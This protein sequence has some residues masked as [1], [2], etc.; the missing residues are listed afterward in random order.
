VRDVT[1]TAVFCTESTECFPLMT[2]KFFFKPF[3]TVT[4]A[5]VAPLI[6]VLIIHIM[7][8]IRCVSIHKLLHF[9]FL[10]AT[11]R[12]I[13]L[14]TGTATSIC[15]HDFSFNYYTWPICHNNNNNNNNN[16]NK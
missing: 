4:V 7:F 3:V 15:T 14:S 8:H 10:P 12:M 1:S 9:C 16:N 2:P 6:T 13:F 11:F 5:P